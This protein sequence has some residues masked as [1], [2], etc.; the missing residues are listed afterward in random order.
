MPPAIRSSRTCSATASSRHRYRHSGTSYMLNTRILG[1]EQ[2]FAIGIRRHMVDAAGHPPRHNGAFG[3]PMTVRERRRAPVWFSRPGR[4][5]HRDAPVGARRPT[6]QPSPAIRCPTYRVRWQPCAPSTLAT[7][8]AT[9]SCVRD[10]GR[11][12]GRYRCASSVGHRSGRLCLSGRSLRLAYRRR[13]PDQNV[14]SSPR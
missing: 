6:R 14:K 4:A 12:I 9:A 13:P 7:A 5:I 3:D 11:R 1:D 10:A 2:A 8:A